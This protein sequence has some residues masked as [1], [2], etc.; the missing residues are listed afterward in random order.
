M[1]L[2]EIKEED[3]KELPKDPLNDHLK[4]RQWKVTFEAF[5]T[6]N[7]ASCNCNSEFQAPKDQPFWSHHKVL[8]SVLLSV[9]PT[10]DNSMEV[11]TTYQ[12]LYCF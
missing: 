8:E 4:G 1:I 6:F 11:E 3:S 2:T 5:D 7:H 10:K 12:P 9:L